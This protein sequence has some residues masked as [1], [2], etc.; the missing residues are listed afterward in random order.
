MPTSAKDIES[1]VQEIKKAHA[2]L[3]KALRDLERFDEEVM[4]EAK[5]Q[6]LKTSLNP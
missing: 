6:Q 1:A 3:M 2:A 4:E 5:I